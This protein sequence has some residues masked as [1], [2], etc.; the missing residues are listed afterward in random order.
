MRGKRKAHLAL[1]SAGARLTPF[2]FIP[3]YPQDRH[4]RLLIRHLELAGVQVQRPV[5]PIAFE[6]RADYVL[7]R[8]REPDGS[9]RECEAR[10]LCGCDGAR[11]N[12]RNQRGAGFAGGTYDD[13]FYIARCTSRC[14]NSMAGRP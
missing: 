14:A 8:L 13:V 3:V 6:D 2:P 5:E 1:K 11:S 9:E 12:V 7:A 4:E 10:F